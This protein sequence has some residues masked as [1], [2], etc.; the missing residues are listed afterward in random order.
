[1]NIASETH[2]APITTLHVT[3][4]SRYLCKIRLVAV[5]LPADNPQQSAEA[6]HVG[7][8]AN[9]MCR[10]CDVGGTER[11]VETDSGYERLFSVRRN[12]AVFPLIA[13]HSYQEGVERTRDKT[14]EHVE[15]QLR[16]AM[17]GVESAVTTLQ[18]ATGVK[19]RIAQHWIE[20]LIERARQLR[21]DPR[22]LSQEKI[23]DELSSWLAA[24]TDTPFNVLLLIDGALL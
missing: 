17:T 12:A 16:A 14:R 18:T 19:D 22:N 3:E 24:Q 4:K 13:A 2:E 1:M 6:S 10:V 9:Q 21:K 20:Q 7:P 15:A 5:Q 11:E 8:G 23:T